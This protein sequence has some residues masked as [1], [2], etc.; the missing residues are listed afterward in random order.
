MIKDTPL[1][2]KTSRSRI[3]LAAKQSFAEKG[4]HATTMADI[5]ARAGLSRATVFNQFGGKDNIIDELA[6]EILDD[7]LQLLEQANKSKNQTT[8]QILQNLLRQIG[9]SIA[10]Y[11]R[12][13]K[14]MYPEV[15]RAALGIGIHKE[16]K[17]MRWLTHDRLS[18]LILRGQAQG[19][20]KNR[21]D[22][23]T[24][25]TAFDSLIF[26]TVSRWLQRESEDENLVD[27]LRQTGDVLLDGFVND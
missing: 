11:R 19:E 22:A 24:M 21:H 23:E 14:S 1:K 8:K 26:G 5:A 27:L 9:E 13:Y 10:M 4:L 18:R 2:T 7:Y 20:L 3:L 17:E 6:A 15:A 16:S 12:F 25:A